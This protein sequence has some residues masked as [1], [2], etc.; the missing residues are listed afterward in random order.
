LPN[1]TSNEQPTAPGRSS[2]P[3]SGYGIFSTPKTK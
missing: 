2:G 3:A 1:E